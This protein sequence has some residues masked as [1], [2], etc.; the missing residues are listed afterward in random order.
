MIASTPSCRF[1]IPLISDKL[2]SSISFSS[3]SQEGYQRVIPYVAN[4]PGGTGAGIPDCT[5]P[6]CRMSSMQSSSFLRRATRPTPQPVAK[7][8]GARAPRLCC[9]PRTTSSSLSPVD[10]QHVDQSGGGQHA[11]GRQRDSRWSVDNLQWLP[12]GRHGAV[13]CAVHHA[14]WWLE[15]DTDADANFHAAR[16]RGRGP[17]RLTA[18]RTTTTCR[19]TRASSPTTSTPPTPTAITSPSCRNWGIGSTARLGARQ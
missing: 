19:T 2:L 15:P 7:A 5:T 10:Y 12:G 18:I 8:S 4:N 6:T 11:A 9:T 17:E 13:R 1:D 16:A 3:Q 14:A